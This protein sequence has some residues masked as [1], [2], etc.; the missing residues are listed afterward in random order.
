PNA[1]VIVGG[2]TTVIVAVLLVAPVPP[3]ADVMGPVV[4]FLTPAAVPVTLMLML[5]LLPAPIDAPVSVIRLPPVIVSVPLQPVVVPLATVRPDG[6][7][8]VNP[9]PVN[10]AAPFG[11]VNV[12]DR[13]VDW[14]SGTVAAPNALA[15]VGGARSLALLVWW[16]PPPRFSVALPGPLVLFW[17][18]AAPPVTVT[19]IVQLPPAPIDPPVNI[20]VLPPLVVRVPPP[21]V[22]ELPLGT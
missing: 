3:F 4:L 8:S 16:V 13:L 9:T 6:R 12:N 11:L 20:I 5:Q 19:L 21:H 17:M 14:F 2:A 22:A 7:V 1:L 10:A 15:I 18:P